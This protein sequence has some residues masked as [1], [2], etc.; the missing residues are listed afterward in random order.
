MARKKASAKRQLDPTREYVV[1]EAVKWRMVARDHVEVRVFGDTVSLPLPWYM[2]L[3][4][5][6][7]PTTLERAAAAY[8]VDLGE[9]PEIGRMFLQLAKAG[10]IRR[11]DEAPKPTNEKSLLDLLDPSIFGKP[12]NRKRISTA[13]RRER[14]VVIPNAFRKSVADEAHRALTTCTEWQ[15]Y[16][17]FYQGFFYHHHNLYDPFA[18]P[19]AM[20]ELHDVFA[21]AATKDFIAGL[22]GQNCSGEPAFA[23]GLY[24]PGDHSLPHSDSDGSRTVAYVWHLTRD[25]DPSWGGDFYWVPNRLSL[26]ASFNTLLLFVVSDNS[27]HFVT[28]VSPYAK[29]QRLA[30]NGWWKNS[31]R[32]TKKRAAPEKPPPTKSRRAGRIIV[33]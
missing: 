2:I 5:F 30:I 11:R 32:R 15:P 31:G 21:S 18:F 22:S 7:R 17:R 9:R 26:P 29:G 27:D 8:G 25:W 4:K 23:A 6:T 28:T 14:L 19:P 1:S 33:I 20:R 12:A 13:L 10:I 3:L 16:E 24:L